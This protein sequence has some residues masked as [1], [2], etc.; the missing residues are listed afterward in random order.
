[1]GEAQRNDDSC[2]GSQSPGAPQRFDRRWSP[3]AFGIYESS[4]GSETQSRRLRADSE[5][6][7]QKETRSYC[8]WPSQAFGI[9]EGALGGTAESGR[10][11]VTT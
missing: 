11:E 4:L 5:G 7:R 10:E 9:N 8:R 1:L 2:T 6:A 3:K